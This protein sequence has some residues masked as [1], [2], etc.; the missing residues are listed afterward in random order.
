M[1]I[2]HLTLGFLFLGLAI[3]GVFLPVL[4]TTPFLLL[5]SF[6]FV[7]SSPRLHRALLRSPLFGPLLSDWDRHRGVRLHVKLQ[8]VTV[9]VLVITLTA[10]FAHLAPWLVV[11]LIALGSIGVVVVLR[12]PTIRSPDD[13]SPP[14]SPSGTDG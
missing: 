3:A 7:R 2:L 5:T 4:P 6:C 12:L 9:I 1:R 11:L 13:P 14:S 8:A 10:L